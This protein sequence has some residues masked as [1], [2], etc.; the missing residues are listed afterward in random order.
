MTDDMLNNMVELITKQVA[1]ID[2]KHGK[3][4]LRLV[5]MDIKDLKATMPHLIIFH[6]DL[7]HQELRKREKESVYTNQSNRKTNKYYYESDSDGST[8]DMPMDYK[9]S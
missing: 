3:E 7:K 5:N 6:E 1:E 2:K 8:V 4:R 9:V